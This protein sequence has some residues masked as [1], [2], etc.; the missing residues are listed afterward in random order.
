MNKKDKNGL[1][2]FSYACQRGH[3]DIAEMII[4]KS[5]EL[6]IEL[7]TKHPHALTPF[8]EVCRNGDF[9]I[10]QLLFQN[11]IKLNID[12]N[13]KGGEGIKLLLEEI[14]LLL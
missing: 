2:A 6:N 9:K 12:V 3:T 13:F 8:Q 5:L 14:L 10:A 11:C 1:T 4:S 7:D